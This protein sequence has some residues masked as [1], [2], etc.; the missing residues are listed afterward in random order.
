MRIVPSQKLKTRDFSETTH[1]FLLGYT[2]ENGDLSVRKLWFGRMPDE[3]KSTQCNI[4]T[5]QKNTFTIPPIK[6]RAARDMWGQPFGCH[7]G[8]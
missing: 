5:L 3:N 2:A 6:R 8:D 7:A 4:E 1:M